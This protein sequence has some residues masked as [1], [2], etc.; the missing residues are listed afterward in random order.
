MWDYRAMKSE[1]EAAGFVGVRRAELGDSPH[2]AF[3]LVV[4]EDRWTNC[5]GIECR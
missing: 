4:N 1:L 3:T 5:L 2:E